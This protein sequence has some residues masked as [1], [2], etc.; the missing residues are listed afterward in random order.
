MVTEDNNT[1][2]KGSWYKGQKNNYYIK[3]NYLKKQDSA[4]G[5]RVYYT[6][7]I[8]HSE[9]NKL[10]DYWSNTQFEKYA[11]ENPV[12]ISEIAHLLPSN[13]PDL[14]LLHSPENL[15]SKLIIW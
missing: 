4:Y 10:E 12:N 7:R 8:K 13:H 6:E 5:N 14:L 1:F 15:L 3:F 2:K 11:L 9:Y